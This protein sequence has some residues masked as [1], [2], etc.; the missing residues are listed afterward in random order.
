M[1]LW[2]LDLV[3]LRR[4]NIGQTGITELQLLQ[5]RLKEGNMTDAEQTWLKFILALICWDLRHDSKRGKAP[6]QIQVGEFDI[7]IEERHI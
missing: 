2:A 6:H 5:E 4:L 1:W 3:D 7:E